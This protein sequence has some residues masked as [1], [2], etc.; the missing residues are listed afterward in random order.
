MHALIWLGEQ[1][2][3]GPQLASRRQVLIG[4]QRLATTSD[5]ELRHAHG[6]LPPQ[7]ASLKHS[8]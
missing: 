8:S 7:S 4:R 5:A 3:P 2:A 1:Y 6:T